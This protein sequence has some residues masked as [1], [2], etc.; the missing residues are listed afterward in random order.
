MDDR[1]AAPL[2]HLRRQ[3]RVEPDGG[4]EVDVQ[5]LLPLVRLDRESQNTRFVIRLPKSQGAAAEAA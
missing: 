3:R 2:E 5:V 4:Q 1:S